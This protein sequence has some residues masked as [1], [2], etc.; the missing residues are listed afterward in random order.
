[1]RW[2]H[3][4]ILGPPH[5]LV[6]CVEI[7][8]CMAFTLYMDLEL[9]GRRGAMLTAWFLV[10]V[11]AALAPALERDQ[12]AFKAVNLVCLHLR[13]LSLSLSLSLSLLS[14]SPLSLSHT[15]THTCV[16]VCVYVYFI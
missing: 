9:V 11:C 16:C 15:H 12:P 13:T 3:A 4:P 5:P 10:C 14:L 6:S 2:C 7:G 1:M 8:V